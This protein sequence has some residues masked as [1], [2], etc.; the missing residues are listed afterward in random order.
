MADLGWIAA[1]E[2]AKV[3]RGRLG[4]AVAA[5]AAAQHDVITLEQLAGLGVA[6][7]TVRYWIATGRLYRLHRGVYAVGH[8]AVG[9]NG[10][11]LAAVLACGP[12]AVLSHRSAAALWEIRRTAGVAIDV[13]A[14]RRAG[15]TR[16]GIA[17]HRY[18]CLIAAEITEVDAIPCTTIARTIVDLAGVVHSSALE[19][20]IH[21]AQVKRRLDR[22]AVAAV[23][24]HLPRRRGNATVRRILRI[25]DSSEDDARSANERR[26]RRIARAAGFPPPRGSFWVGLDDLAAG[27]VEVD[28]AWPQLK[29]AVEIDSSIYHGTDRAIVNDPRRDRALMLAGWQVVR[30]TDRDLEEEPGVVVTQLRAFMER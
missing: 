12:G 5:I 2:T 11:R 23:L 7:R 24:D 21:Q 3:A 1:T 4:R 8:P 20:A 16:P 22:D 14:P 29:L 27:G 9:A 26:F 13:T 6:D 18:D 15:R 19:Y 10:H 30:F 17:V 28:F 25:S